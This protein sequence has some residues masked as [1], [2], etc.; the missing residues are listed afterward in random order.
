MVRLDTPES[1]I[2][3]DF[4]PAGSGG[5]EDAGITDSGGACVCSGVFAEVFGMGLA[6]PSTGVT[7]TGGD[8]T[9]AA[10]AGPV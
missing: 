6:S 10:L 3:V 5:A 7:E 9:T 1:V 4:A 8:V 2:T